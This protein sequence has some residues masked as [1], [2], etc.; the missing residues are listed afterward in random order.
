VSHPSVA[1]AYRQRGEL[2]AQQGERDRAQA[3]ARKALEIAERLQGGKP[4]SVDTGLGYL[5]LGRILRESGDAQ[6]ARTALQS[7]AKHLANSVGAEHP[8][9]QLAQQLLVQQ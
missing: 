7:A 9:T 1:N 8:D 2:E 6:S 4:F 3:D 5:T